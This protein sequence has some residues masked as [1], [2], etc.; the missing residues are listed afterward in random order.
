ME[1]FEKLT[2]NQQHLRE[3]PR[4]FG[5]PP[6]SERLIL[7]SPRGPYCWG[8]IYLVKAGQLTLFPCCPIPLFSWYPVPLF[9]CF[10]VDL[11]FKINSEFASDS[12]L[13]FAIQID[14]WPRFSRHFAFCTMYVVA[15]VLSIRQ[16]MH[17]VNFGILMTSIELS[18]YFLEDCL[19]VYYVIL[20]C[21]LCET[22]WYDIYFAWIFSC[23]F[24]LK[25]L[26]NIKFY[27][28]PTKLPSNNG[29]GRKT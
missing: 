25:S 8:V 3:L 21:L 15:V 20:F 23:R 29:H 22:V 11:N 19:V 26:I 27:T 14:F 12:R 5:A 6:K 1:V 17:Y 7:C 13:R 2:V 4:H 9:P 18:F 28:K 10:P 16:T 24:P